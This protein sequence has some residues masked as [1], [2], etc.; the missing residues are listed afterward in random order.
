MEDFKI[1]TCSPEASKIIADYKPKE[2]VKLK[3]VYPFELL[4]VAS[5]FVMPS[6]RMTFQAL[7]NLCSRR[8]NEGKVFR[9]LKHEAQQ[10]FEVV[11]VA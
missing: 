1:F 11:R 7:K 10:L 8:S 5:C 9:C 3:D 4:E 6:N 2:K